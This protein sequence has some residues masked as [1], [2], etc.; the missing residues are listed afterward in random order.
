[1]F[2]ENAS[3]YGDRNTWPVVGKR[4]FEM[5]AASTVHTKKRALAA[6]VVN[7]LLVPD[8]N[9]AHLVSLTDITGVMKQTVYN[10]LDYKGGYSLKD[11]AVALHTYACAHNHTKDDRWLKGVN[12]CLAFITSMYDENKGWSDWMTYNRQKNNK[13]SE[14]SESAAVWALGY[15]YATSGSAGTKD[16]AYGL[17]GK[18]LN[19]G[20]KD[21]KAKAYATLGIVMVLKCDGTNAD[22]S[23]LLESQ[24]NE[25]YS[26]YPADPYNSRQWHEDEIGREA[27]LVPLALLHASDILNNKAYLSAA[28]RALRFLWKNV[29]SEG[30]YSPNASER[31]EF[32][33]HNEEKAVA[34][35]NE[36][37]LMT[38]AYS[39]LYR[40]TGEPK[41]LKITNEIHNWYLGD[42]SAG[43]SLYDSSGG[44]CYAYLSGRSISPEQTAESTCSYWLSH[45]A[46]LETYFSEITGG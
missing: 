39:K 30:V 10:I 42:N 12:T 32:K 23:G 43:K 33:P 5:L 45:F 24:A 46:V 2:H 36:A 7:P 22:V 15:L 40:I 4:L 20:F 13:S 28:K 9:L 19:Q 3:L 17:I 44:G 31:Q 29:F 41:Y 8:L 21:I 11:N 38:A 26:S 1:M 35:A 37:Y 34:N 27:A 6:T 18:L 16:Y 25:M 14:L